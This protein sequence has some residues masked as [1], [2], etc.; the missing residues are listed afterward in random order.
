MKR[1]Q[2][3]KK[4]LTGTVFCLLLVQLLLLFVF[5]LKNSML[6]LDMDSTLAI[7]HAV[8]IWREGA[9]FFDHFK[10]MSSLEIDALTFFAVPLYYLIQDW[11]VTLAVVYGIYSVAVIAVIFD[12]GRQIGVEPWASGVAASFFFVP[13]SAGKLSY[14][15][16]LFMG[17]GQYGLRVLTLFLLLD[18]LIQRKHGKKF[19]ILSVLY[20][21]LLLL[22]TLSA[23]N[24]IFLMGILPLMLYEAVTIIKDQKLQ[25]KSWR[26]GILFCSF[27]LVA[28]VL[29]LRPQMGEEH[30]SNLSLMNAEGLF[31]NF[32]NCLTGIFLLSGG[33][34][35]LSNISVFSVSGI[36][37]AGKF[38]FTLISLIVVPALLM[39]YRLYKK[40]HF[41]GLAASILVLNLF[42]LLIVDTRYGALIFEYRY[43]LLWFCI[44]LLA[45]AFCIYEVVDLEKGICRNQYMNHAAIGLLV[46]FVALSTVGGY[47]SL[48]REL[49]VS[50]Y[51][52]CEVVLQE[53]KKGEADSVLSCTQ[54]MS[55]G[56]MLRFLDPDGVYYDISQNEESYD[57]YILDFYLNRV[58][59]T[60]LGDKNLLLLREGQ[61]ETLPQYIRSRYQCI[62]EWDGY[63]LYW[64][65]NNPWDLQRGVP[66]NIG[67]QEDFPYTKGYEVVQG[68]INERGELIAAEGTGDI[69]KASNLQVTEG[70]YSITLSYQANP[71]NCAGYIKIV[72]TETGEVLASGD[73]TGEQDQI[74]LDSLEVNGPDKWEI[75]IGKEEEGNICIEKLQFQKLK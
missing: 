22:T 52:D 21:L 66:D 8:E 48:S 49:E 20:F 24:Y 72:S 5:N 13:W 1:V 35:Y 70:T 75:H 50:N 11:Q 71:N 62:K 69:L 31:T 68:D 42:V 39:K 38:L 41:F 25:M 40:N 64:T 30:R 19:G 7:R 28:L 61:Y 54:D 17:G 51:P 47:R 4:L 16:M 2:F 53:A 65:E 67:L 12:I 10:Y 27:L 29:L 74:T 73:L 15:L 44:W 26:K 46:F 14:P 60:D 55:V 37:I 6:L 9:L 34:H 56:A 57:P 23:G 45:V 43:H 63:Q 59:R 58:D 32:W 36:V 33:T 18:L 3:E